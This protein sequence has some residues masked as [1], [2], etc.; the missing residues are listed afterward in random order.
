MGAPVGNKNAAKAKQWSAAIE[1]ALAKRK[2]GKAQALDELAEK[3]L[4]ACDSADLAALRE[5]GDRLDGKPAQSVAVG[6]EPGEEFITKIVREIV[7]PKN[8]NG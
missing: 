8:R 5:L 1:R 2:G 6:N 4:T 3:L 7:R